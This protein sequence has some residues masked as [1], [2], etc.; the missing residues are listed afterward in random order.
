MASIPT[1]VD[2]PSDRRY[3]LRIDG[4][5]VASAAYDLS[6]RVLSIN[7][8]ETVP[9]HRNNGYAAHLMDG[10]VDDARTRSL[11]IRP[12]CS[13]AAQYMHERPATHDLYAA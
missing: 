13:Y 4:A 1:V 2:N 12:R 11:T 9:E 7:H 10:V 5:I 8:V 6:G 3:E